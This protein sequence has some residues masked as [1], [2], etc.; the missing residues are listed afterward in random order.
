[1]PGAPPAVLGRA[2]ELIE[3]ELQRAIARLAPSLRA[4]ARYHLGWTNLDGTELPSAVGGKRLRPALAVLSAEAAGAAASVAVPGAVAVELI[5]NFSLLHD[6]IIDGDEQRRHR[7]TVWKAW[8]VGDGIIV[9]DALHTLAFE[10]LL[11]DP[12]P[13]RV[14]A[15]QRLVHS[16]AAMIFGQSDDMTFNDRDSVSFDD[17][18]TMEANKTGALLA[19]SA[20]VGA[21]LAE[22]DH[23]V[24]EGLSLFGAELGIAFQAI[25]DLLGIWGD[26]AATGKPAMSDL[27][28]R[29]R[30]MPVTAAMAADHPAAAEL[31]QLYAVDHLGD[32]DLTRMADLVLV[33]GGRD[34][35]EQEAHRRIAASAKALEAAGISEGAHQALVELSEFVLGR[36][37]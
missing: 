27:R 23:G 4:P 10:V 19:Y 17:C 5:H 2:I 35:T 30:S 7:T 25:D 1:M 11:A 22:A 18:V 21:V 32:D 20:S 33:A 16:T 3:P 37:H 31:K 28:E 29:K 12:T 24:I 14:A 34:R 8:G 6:D 13:A 9:G 15:T 26:P 36:S